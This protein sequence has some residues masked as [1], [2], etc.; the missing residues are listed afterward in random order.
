MADAPTAPVPSG[1]T[2]APLE[3]R[4][5]KRS[6]ATHRW[7]VDNV[8]LFPGD[9]L[10]FDDVPTLFEEHILPGN[11]PAAP[12]LSE[13]DPVI[14][15]GSCFAVEL[16]QFLDSAGF[17]ATNFYVPTGLNNTFALVD[18][19]SWCVRG[20][21]TGRGYRYERGE[22][23]EIRE[24]TPETERLD[25]V[26]QLRDAGCFVFTLGLSEVWEDRETGQVFWRGVPAEIFDEDRHVHRL[27]TVD[28]NEANI[29][30]LIDLL[31]SLNPDA[32]VVLTL[33][34]V[35]LQA[36]FR[37]IS[38]ITADAVS[39]SVLRVA[40]D[41]VMNAGLPNVYYWPSFELVRWCGGFYDHR[42]STE[43]GA[44]HPE[45]F[46]VYTIVRTFVRSFYGEERAATFTERLAAKGM[47]AKPPHR[48]RAL[49]RR[50][51][52]RARTAVSSLLPG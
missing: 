48:M 21:S 37:S 13:D 28:E 24:W 18:F 14:T 16:R 47:V 4:S 49:G 5:S 15:L 38:C 11:A 22:G 7:H 8:K 27:S 12:L 40:L 39:K 32:P 29:R 19:M 1:P 17:S 25:Y 26:Q 52:I 45:R 34:P 2:L 42:S 31:R 6:W 46:L 41:N 51:R 20:Q 23:G 35:P 43:L 50:A 36:T 9:V 3:Y 30:T 10:T 44:R 33:S